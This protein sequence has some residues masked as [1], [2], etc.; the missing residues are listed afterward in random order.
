MRH[1][2]PALT[3][4]LT[5]VFGGASARA[6]APGQPHHHRPRQHAHR[7]RREQFGVPRLIEFLD[8]CAGNT[9]AD[10]LA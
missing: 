10:L 1:A 7:S 5:V 2:A 6:Q 3:L 9:P 4:A 8:R